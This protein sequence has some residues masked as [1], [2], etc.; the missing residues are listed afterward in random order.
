MTNRNTPIIESIINSFVI[1]KTDRMLNFDCAIRNMLRYKVSPIELLLYIND[2]IDW[3]SSDDDIK[4][5]KCLNHDT[6]FAS[7]MTEKFYRYENFKLTHP[8]YYDS[9]YN[10][11]K[12][13]L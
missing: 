6:I 11:V 12:K 5:Y 9:D 4:K 1:D 7:R 8:N 13:W 3:A 2:A 10:E